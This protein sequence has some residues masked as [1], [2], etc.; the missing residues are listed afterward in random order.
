MDDMIMLKLGAHQQVSDQTGIFRNLH[1]DGV[2]NCPHRGQSMGIRS[3][4]AGSCHKMVR[5]PWIPPLQNDF[6]TSEHLA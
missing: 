5:I 1:A 6:D 4:P 2:F 3:D